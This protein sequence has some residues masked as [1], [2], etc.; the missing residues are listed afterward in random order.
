MGPKVLVFLIF[1]SSTGCDPERRT[2]CEWYL[3]A[4]PS[5]IGKTDHGLIPV[6]ARN[7]VANK[8]DCR[9]QTNLDYAKKNHLRAFK[10][11]DLKV[12]D[13]GKPRTIKEITFCEPEKI[14]ALTP[15]PEE[16]P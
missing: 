3:T 8:Q 15:V 10:Y 7:Y 11:D 16:H 9:L 6:C 4:D 2:K 12:V 1:I 13:Y 14:T 5:R